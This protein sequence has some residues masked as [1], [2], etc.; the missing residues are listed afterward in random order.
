MS[1]IGEFEREIIV[2]PLEE[3]IPAKKPAKEPEKVPIP[4]KKSKNNLSSR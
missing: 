4:L 3:P 1:R 2:E